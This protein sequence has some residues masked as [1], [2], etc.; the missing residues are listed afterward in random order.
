MECSDNTEIAVHD[1]SNRVASVMYYEGVTT[2]R[3]SIGRNMGLDSLIGVVMNFTVSC[4]CSLYIGQ[5]NSY[6]EVRLGW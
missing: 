3:I 6:P 5:N 1:N 2:N 4:S